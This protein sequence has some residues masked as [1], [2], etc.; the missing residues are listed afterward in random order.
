MLL[1]LQARLGHTMKPQEN[2]NHLQ[3]KHTPR[4]LVN[5]KIHQVKSRITLSNIAKVEPIQ[6]LQARPGH[7][8]QAQEPGEH[9]QKVQ[10]Q[11]GHMIQAQGPGHHQ[12]EKVIQ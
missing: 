4:V 3:G 12:Q 11:P 9:H 5:I 2:G 1:V 7:M 6:I 10:L 8:I